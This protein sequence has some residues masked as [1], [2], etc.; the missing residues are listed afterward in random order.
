M[1]LE[2]GEKNE[3][4]G[5]YPKVQQRRKHPEEDKENQKRKKNKQ[6][7]IENAKEKEQNAKNKEEKRKKERTGTRTTKDDAGSKKG[8]GYKSMG[9]FYHSNYRRHYHHK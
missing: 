3:N 5:V 4:K 2:N 9:S 1:R 8:P 7:K 6:E